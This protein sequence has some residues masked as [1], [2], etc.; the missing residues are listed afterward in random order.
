MHIYIYIKFTF[1]HLVDTFIQRN[2]QMSTMEAIKIN[3]RA[4]TRK[5]YNKSQLT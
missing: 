4:M 3:K 2:L 1:S 5:C